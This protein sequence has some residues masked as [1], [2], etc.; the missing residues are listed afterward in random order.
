MD[1]L[2]VFVMITNNE[3]IISIYYYLIRIYYYLIRI[4]IKI[5][6]K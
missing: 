6:I 1:F 2:V 3:P 5:K 4:R